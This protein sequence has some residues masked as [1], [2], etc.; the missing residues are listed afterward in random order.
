M[1]VL[2]TPSASESS[3]IRFIAKLLKKFLIQAIACINLFKKFPRNKSLKVDK[4]S[5]TKGLKVKM[6]EK[7]IITYLLKIFQKNL[8]T[9]FKITINSKSV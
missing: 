8:Q 5:D 9:T 2:G 4:I 6:S 7:I 3:R 1:S